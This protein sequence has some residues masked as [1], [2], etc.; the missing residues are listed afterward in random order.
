MPLDDLIPTL[1]LAIGPVILISGVGLILLSMT[2]RFGRTIDRS[3]SLTQ[4]LRA[5]SEMDRA[6]VLAELAILWRRA[7]I[8]RAGIA[9]AVLSVLLAALLVIS[10]FLGALFRLG[11]A[12]LLVLLFIMCLMCLVASLVLFILDINLSLK[13]LWLEI[14][15]EGRGQ[16]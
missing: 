15:A 14:P 6:K 16:E 9:L 1:Q 2:N 11:I 3:R 7:K 8:V 4:D 12:V 5:A 10:L 13:A